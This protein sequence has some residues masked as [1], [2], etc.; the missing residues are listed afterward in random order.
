MTL[1]FFFL[2]KFNSEQLVFTK[3]HSI[4]IDQTVLSG[5][6]LKSNI[7]LLQ[8]EVMTMKD[9]WN[10]MK[11]MAETF[12]HDLDSQIICWIHKAVTH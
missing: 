6:Q 8:A 3:W 1:F 2:F 10:E 9:L 4:V 12:S 11:D 7:S 5:V